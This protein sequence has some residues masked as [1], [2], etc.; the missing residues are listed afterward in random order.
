MR[1]AYKYDPI[2][3][4]LKTKVGISLPFNGNSVFNSTYTTSE[5]LK[6]NLINLLLTEKGER[7]FDNE[8]GIGIRNILFENISDL[9]SIKTSI[10][11]DI[12]R[13]VPHLIIRELNITSTD[14]NEIDIYLKYAS[15][16]D[17]RGDEIT[18]T[19]TQ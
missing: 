10:K 7:F 8:F 9:E 2:D 1:K 18:L 17:M 5:Q 14:N 6:H 4:D 15:D 16:T 12:V 3:L 13:Y 19:F 11:K